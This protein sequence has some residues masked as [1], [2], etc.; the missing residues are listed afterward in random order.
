MPRIFVRGQLLAEVETTTGIHQDSA[1]QSFFVDVSRVIADRSITIWHPELAGKEGRST[2]EGLR[3]IDLS[4]RGTGA[5]VLPDG[6]FVSVD[7][8]APLVER[9]TRRGRPA[10]F[11]PNYGWRR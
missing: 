9:I 10:E 4:K 8:G 7:V 11:V 2:E 3:T 6:G 5:Q 1:G